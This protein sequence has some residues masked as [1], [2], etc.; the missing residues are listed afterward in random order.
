MNRKLSQ[1]RRQLTRIAK[2]ESRV[3]LVKK[4]P[5]LGLI[6]VFVLRGVRG[7]EKAFVV[8]G[9]E[10]VLKIL[11]KFSATY[12][13]VEQLGNSIN[14]LPHSL[15]GIVTTY[16]DLLERLSSEITSLVG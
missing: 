5:Q 4:S 3:A 2:K 16:A 15:R 6:F 13:E 14:S 9:E 12:L 8:E 11:E 10:E 1:G 7:L